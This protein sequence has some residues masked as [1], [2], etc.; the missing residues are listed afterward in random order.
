[1]TRIPSGINGVQVFVIIIP[2]RFG[3]RKQSET[4]CFGFFNALGDELNFESIFGNPNLRLSVRIND[5]LYGSGTIPKDIRLR[6]KPMITC[7]FQ[8]GFG[9]CPIV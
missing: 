5:F 6:F 2:C 1:M 8:L 4:V 9:M 3:R 7:P